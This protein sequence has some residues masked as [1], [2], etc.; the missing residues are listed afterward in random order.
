MIALIVPASSRC[1][2][3]HWGGSDA[4]GKQLTIVDI[5]IV[6]VLKTAQ[7]GYIF[8][9]LAQDDN[10]RKFQYGSSTV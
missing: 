9:F 4:D 7:K 10:E 8:L 2:H 6:L 5:N 3:L 1:F